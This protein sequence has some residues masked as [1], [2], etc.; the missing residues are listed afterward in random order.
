MNLN[1]K[2]KMAR[3]KELSPQL[4]SRLCELKSI[5]WSYSKIKEKHP[6]IP[7]GTIRSTICLEKTRINNISKPR[8]G[9]PRQLTEE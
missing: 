5:G 6:E 8:S 4:R 2:S 1:R 7:L 9:R 3:K